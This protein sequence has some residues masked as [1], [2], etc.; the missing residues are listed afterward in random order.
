MKSQI[1]C[2]L[3]DIVT[4]YQGFIIKYMAKSKRIE[5]FLPTRTTNQIAAFAIWLVRY[6]SSTDGIRVSL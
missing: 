2:A 5:A 4:I 1:Y 3:Q 6:L